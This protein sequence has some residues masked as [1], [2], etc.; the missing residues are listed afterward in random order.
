MI[1]SSAGEIH[2]RGGNPSSASFRAFRTHHHQAP[3]TRDVPYQG[4]RVQYI[5]DAL[6]CSTPPGDSQCTATTLRSYKTSK[7][8]AMAN[9]FWASPHLFCRGTREKIYWDTFSWPWKGTNKRGCALPPPHPRPL[10]W[11]FRLS[12]DLRSSSNI[13]AVKKL[14]DPR[15]G[16]VSGVRRRLTWE[17]EIFQR[18]TVSVWVCVLVE[19]KGGMFRMRPMPLQPNLKQERNNCPCLPH[20]LHHRPR[21][22][23]RSTAAGFTVQQP[24][25]AFAKCSY[26]HESLKTFCSSM[27]R[28]PPNIN[29]LKFL[30]H[31]CI[32][33]D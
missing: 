1:S 22:L 6:L 18:E 19:G 11:R 26:M 2:S 28:I 21:W 7:S 23:E 25:R 9:F 27:A 31:R 24:L 32:T 33:F 5:W 17:K 30:P 12:F 8:I 29:V 20:L 16:R 3:T 14:I 4:C 13:F 10:C 15:N